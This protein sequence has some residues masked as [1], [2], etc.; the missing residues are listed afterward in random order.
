MPA[1]HLPLNAQSRATSA[2]REEGARSLRAMAASSRSSAGPSTI[3]DALAGD[4]AALVQ[5]GLIV[6]I[7][8]DGAIRY[9]IACDPEGSLS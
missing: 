2:P 9:A 5:A 7:K 4:L 8:Q 3:V 6:P 1:S